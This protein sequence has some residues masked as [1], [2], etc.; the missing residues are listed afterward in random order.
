MSQWPTIVDVAKE[1]GLS[2][3][4]VSRVLNGRHGISDETRQKVLEVCK[5]LKYRPLR[6]RS[7][8]NARATLSGAG[9]SMGRAVER[10][11]EIVLCGISP[12]DEHYPTGFEMVMLHGMREIVQGRS[13]IT[14]TVHY[15]DQQ[16][17]QLGLAGV[18]ESLAGKS[19][20]IFQAGSDEAVVRTLL[21][22]G[23]PVVLA[24]H[25]YADLAVNS[26]GSDNVAGGMMAV[27]HLV[28]RGHRRIGWL[29]GPKRIQAWYQRYLG[30]R[31]GM[32][33][34]GLAVREGDIRGMV[35]LEFRTGT[36]VMSQWLAE[37][38]LPTAIVVPGGSV[39]FSVERSLILAGQ[40]MGV[41]LSVVCF[42]NDL[43][44]TMCMVRPT[45]VA[46]FPQQIGRK[47]M[48]RLL[49]LCEGEPL[50]EDTPHKVVVPMQLMVGESVREVAG[51]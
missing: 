22:R 2:H 43:A 32:M 21:E 51:E 45:R 16:V 12:D 38:D 35:D 24:D 47:A 3:T 9:V 31:A 50:A 28:E 6:T 40:R 23:V 26:V 18:I 17:E 39:A 7:G 30:F 10:Q 44:V 11:V 13:E 48:V 36:E 27:Q 42:D 14:C 46:T 33:E 34:A 19:G 1:L 37:G 29:G 15:W 49:Q 20:V 5:R 41:D 4:T 25:E 8:S